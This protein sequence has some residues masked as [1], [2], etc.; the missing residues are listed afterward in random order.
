MTLLQRKPE[1]HVHFSGLS[2]ADRTA[3]DQALGPLYE[4]S[5][6]LQDCGQ[7]EVIV[8]VHPEATKPVPGM[9]D[10]S[11]G[12]MPDPFGMPSY[13]SDGRFRTRFVEGPDGTMHAYN[14]PEF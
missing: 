7:G 8:L 9:R 13:L 1:A 6:Q 2:Q 4:R 10:G 12:F 5:S 14:T 3:M 11:G